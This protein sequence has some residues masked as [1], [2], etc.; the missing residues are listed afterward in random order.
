MAERFAGLIISLQ[1]GFSTA[2]L[3]EGNI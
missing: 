1:T 2:A 3:A